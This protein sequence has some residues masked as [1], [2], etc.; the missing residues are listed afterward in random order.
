MKVL[1]RDFADGQT[2]F[3]T[4]W[5]ELLAASAR[6]SRDVDITTTAEW[7][8]ALRHSHLDD[9][10]VKVAVAYTDERLDGVFPYY[11]SAELVRGIPCR[12]LAAVSQLYSG[13]NRLLARQPAAFAGA[14]LDALLADERAW[15]WLGL[16]LLDDSESYSAL[17]AA[18]GERGLRLATIGTADSPYIDL[19]SEWDACFNALG[20]K[21]RWL[22]RTAR[23]RMSESGH[24]EHRA[25][26]HPEDVAPLLTAIFDV[27][28]ASWKESSG[29]SITAIQTQARFYRDFTPVA[30]ARGWLDGHVLLLDGEPVAY[31]YGIR[32]GPVFHDLKESYKLAY[33]DQSPG[34]VLKTFVIPALIADGV[35]RYDFCG[36]CDEFKMKWT[37][38]TYRRCNLI[39]ENTTL[40]A[41]ALRGVGTMLN[42]LRGSSMDV[43]ALTEP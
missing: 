1:L 9:A 31:I 30:A 14:L 19:P 40:R 22:L 7:S 5:L 27:E 41:R 20:K 8:A 10:P 34:H 2:E 11:R 3:S 13:R 39:I 43:A 23:K 28:K 18:V 35:T 25:Y 26:R 17:L 21:F 16:T 6:D 24:L 15:D 36:K 32:L 37:E 4:A 42:R 12:K 29:S 38:L 33:R